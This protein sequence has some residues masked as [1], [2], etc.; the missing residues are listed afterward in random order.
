MILAIAK[1]NHLQR[2]F[3]CFAINDFGERQI[4]MTCKRNISHPCKHECSKFIKFNSL[5]GMFEVN[6]E[7]KRIQDS[8]KT[9][10]MERFTTIVHTF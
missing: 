5:S 3:I 9:S 1:I 10:N 2:C 7:H 8:H 4:A 6:K